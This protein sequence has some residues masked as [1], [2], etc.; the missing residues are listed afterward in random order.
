[1]AVLSSL[2]NWLFRIVVALVFTCYWATSGSA[3][4]IYLKNGKKIEGEIIE[5]KEDHV[6]VRFEEGGQA[7]YWLDEIER[8]EDN[9]T[10][11]QVSLDTDLKHDSAEEAEWRLVYVRKVETI[12]TGAPAE[13]D[14]PA[15]AEVLVGLGADYFYVVDGKKTSIYDFGTRRVRYVMSDQAVDDISL[16]ALVAY[17]SAELQNRLMLG[18]AFTAANVVGERNPFR[19]F[20]LEALF[21]IAKKGGGDVALS[22]ELTDGIYH[23]RVGG[24]VKV[25]YRL[26]EFAPAGDRK[27]MF[28]KY[29]LY[30][31][32]LHPAV[33]RSIVARAA[34]PQLLVY[35]M[36]N[37]P[38]L[39]ARIRLELKGVEQD[40]QR[41]SPP[42]KLVQTARDADNTALAQLERML[43]EVETNE[44]KPPLT[45]RQF[46]EMTDQAIAQGQY[47]DAMLMATECGLQT[48]EYLMDHIR[49][50]ASYTNTD[51]RLA[52]FVSAMDMSSEEK[53]KTSLQILDGIDR[54]GLSRGHVVDIM[55]AD[56]KA[57]LGQE[58]EARELFVNVLT[59]NPHIAGVYK[60]LGEVY[61]RFY[62]MRTAWKCWDTA[63]RLYPQH[64]MLQQINE[65]EAKLLDQYPEFF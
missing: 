40:Q 18:E 3:E 59:V 20:D 2:W 38:A 14:L 15:D 30:E 17:R 43:G 6:T 54:T 21:G 33:R 49:Q 44:S 11:S 35:E 31:T 42:S 24:E 13:K 45:R 29:L 61:H 56:A 27:E 8:I 7:P 32:N 26:S 48:G 51:R 52:Q 64:P 57:A 62:D 37:L 22:E 10:R 39:S 47:L 23:Y 4:T 58:N 9:K 1:M 50:L 19:Q 63:R 28:E 46:V 5:R 60:D 53:T 16:F 12:S 34:I 36:H 41:Y 55:R 25:E 65:Y